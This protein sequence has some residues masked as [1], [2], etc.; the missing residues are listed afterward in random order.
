MEVSQRKFASDLGNYEL[1][2]EKYLRIAARR[3]GKGSGAP[4]FGNA[5]AV[6]HLIDNAWEKQTRR[7]SLEARGGDPDPFHFTR[8]DLL[9]NRTLDMSR[10][11]PLQ[12]LRPWR[13]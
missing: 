7:V 4:G 1:A 11:E 2:D 5:R 10:S 6:S 3:L 12:A 8:E 9:G 13:A